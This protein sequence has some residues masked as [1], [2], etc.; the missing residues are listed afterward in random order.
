MEPIATRNE[1]NILGRWQ[2]YLPRHSQFRA[3]RNSRKEWLDPNGDNSIASLQAN[4][5][6]LHDELGDLLELTPPLLPTA[7]AT[8]VDDLEELYAGEPIYADTPQDVDMTESNAAR[9]EPQC[10]CPCRQ[11]PVIY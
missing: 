6:A 1:N 11:R 3:L 5:E 10:V 9:R 7:P 8:D 2:V 4:A